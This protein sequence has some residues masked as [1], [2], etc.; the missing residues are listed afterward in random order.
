MDKA[1]D[2]LKRVR[3]IELRA[4]HLA[5]E[6]FAGQYQSGFR[7]QGLDFDDFR[8]YMPGDDPRFI[9]WKV[10][11]RMNSLCPP[12]PGGTGTGRHSGGGRQRL[13]AL[14]LLRG[15][16]LQTGLCGGS[17]GSARLQRCPERRQMRPPHLREQPLP[18]H[19]P[20][21]GVKQTLR[22]VREIVASKTMEPT[23][24]F[25]M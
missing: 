13:H 10:T 16:R 3:R 9:D 24:T 19:P 11:A 20:A 18:L 17:S 5:T 2:I 22:I 1:S 14:R 6:N 12:F 4:R 8:E 23:R 21:K 7:G 15:P 25:P